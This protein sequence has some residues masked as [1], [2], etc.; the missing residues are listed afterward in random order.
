M[1]S[2]Y[3]VQ[4]AGANIG[5]GL[6]GIGAI[7]RDTRERKEAEA[8][9]EAARLRK[10]KM[11]ESMLDAFNAGDP[12]RMMEVAIEYP[13]VAELAK[14]SMGMMKDY[15]VKEATD[16]ATQV[17]TNPQQAGA[18]AERRITLLN[19][20]G[21]NPSDTM[22][23]YD[24]YLQNPEGAL[25]E[26]QMSLASLNPEAYKAYR[27]FAQPD[28]MGTK[29]VGDYLVDETGNV[30]FDASGGGSGTP[31]HGLTPLI[32]RNPATGTYQAYLPNKEG[33]MT[34]I[35]TPQ[36]QEFVPDAGRMGFN[37]A[38]ITEQTVGEASA[39]LQA[40]PIVGQ[41][42]RAE[43]LAATQ[44]QR[45]G[46]VAS[47]EDQFK[48]LDEVTNEVRDQA[49]MMTTGFGGA[50]T[51]SIPGTP[52]ADLAANLE[53]L[54][55]AAGFEKLQEMRDNS[56][57]GGALGSVTERELALL[58]ATWGSLNQ[59]Q[60][61]EQ[62]KR[63]LDR[64][65]EQVRDSWNRVDAAYERDYGEKYFQTDDVTQADEILR[66]AGIIQ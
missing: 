61:Q 45:A 6:A 58:Q 53:T 38:N 66:R 13:E 10:A 43:E 28:E 5:Q 31:E 2:P 18:L 26:L 32:F 11:Q 60:S 23:F 33:G 40:A 1:V 55:A 16:F 52:A 30:I 44:G 4:P 24:S 27:D 57:T 8:A 15:Q 20:Q 56:P 14:Q 7:L 37:P 25:Q 9:E 49:G 35:N 29:V 46:A 36:G 12:S 17:L 47:K 21:R 54:Q 42:A 19:M 39:A 34:P 65:Q 62:F 48:L 51:R 41:A 59:S 3:Y 64:F 22:A 63:N 50:L